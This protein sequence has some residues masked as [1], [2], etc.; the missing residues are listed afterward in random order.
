M[1]NRSD[2]FAAIERYKQGFDEHDDEK[3][4]DAFVWPH[5]LLANGTTTTLHEPLV[6][7]AEMKATKNW[8]RSI[9]WEIDV[10]AASNTSAHVA[11]RNVERVRADGSL[12]ECVSG[13]YAL[14]KTDKG[15]KIFAIS[16]ITS[17]D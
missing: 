8:A 9:N 16:A 10:I 5:T 14:T 17:P 3:I 2:V 13:F 12:I 6:T 1:S 15:W 7:T 4:R 11:V